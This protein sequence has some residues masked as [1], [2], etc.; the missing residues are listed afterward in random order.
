MYR[1]VEINNLPARQAPKF[2]KRNKK[3]LS[4][5]KVL[6]IIAILE[7][8]IRKTP[9]AK[10]AY[11]KISQK[12]GEDLQTWVDKHKNLPYDDP[13]NMLCLFLKRAQKA[14]GKLLFYKKLLEKLVKQPPPKQEE[15]S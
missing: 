3:L 15:E 13:G 2:E 4:E 10:K 5:K 1:V 14:P 6:E 11:K 7:E 8:Q 9:H 12:Y